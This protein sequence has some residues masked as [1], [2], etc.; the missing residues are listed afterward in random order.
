MKVII[1]TGASSGIGLQVA[2]YLGA[3]GHH[4]YGISRSKIHEKNV[5]GIQADVT[6]FEQLN[7]CYKDIYDIE[8]RIDVLINNA[9]FG[10]S[11]SIEDTSIEDANELMNVNF[12]GVFHSTKAAL[13]L[14][15]QTGGGKIINMS[16]VASRL[17]I[18]FQAFYSSSKAA[19]NAFSEALHNE[20]S[21]YK[22]QVCSVM[23][24]DIKTGFTK[25]RKK[26]EIDSPIYQKRIDKSVGVME[27]DERNGMDP[28][29]AAKT[30][31]RLI[32]RRHMPL[33]KTIGFKYKIFV[34]LHKFLPA[35]LANFVVGAIYGFKRIK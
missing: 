15:R 5:K 19:I 30:I 35:K 7:T 1:V 29:V 6:N 4:V 31:T 3:K 2:N 9:G 13:P 8:G 20:V 25:N 10:I 34:I 28:E 16:S 14:M 18:P 22:I 24:G 27:H 26:N 33:Y 12:M 11:G 21:P 32:K 23:P 17:A